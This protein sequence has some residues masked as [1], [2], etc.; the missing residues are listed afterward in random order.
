VPLLHTA[1][2]LLLFA[3]AGGLGCTSSGLL[4]HLAKILTASTTP[5]ALVVLL[6]LISRFHVSILLLSDMLVWM[7][8]AVCVGVVRSAVIY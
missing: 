1:R 4:I 5:A 6:L 3:F 7:V 2:L 8:I